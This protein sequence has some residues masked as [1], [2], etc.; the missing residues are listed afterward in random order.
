MTTYAL[1]V[2]DH[3]TPMTI[4]EHNAKLREM[5]QYYFDKLRECEAFCGGKLHRGRTGYTAL[6]G[7][8]EYVAIKITI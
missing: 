5:P 2:I 1:Y 8:T 7:N 4:E 6:K 3:S